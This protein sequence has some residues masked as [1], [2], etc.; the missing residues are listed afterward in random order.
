[1]S[2]YY[3][4]QDIDGDE[5]VILHCDSLA[6]AEKAMRAEAARLCNRPEHFSVWNAKGGIEVL[7]CPAM[8]D[9]LPIE[10]LK[11]MARN[12]RSTKR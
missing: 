8:Q 3:V 11:A 5:C 1:M 9:F 6:D 12:T 10:Q 7:W 2:G 4:M